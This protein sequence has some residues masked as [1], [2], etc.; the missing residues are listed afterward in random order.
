M[1]YA[2]IDTH[3]SSYEDV[4]KWVDEWIATQDTA[5]YHRGI[6]LLP[7]RW[8]KVIENGGNYFH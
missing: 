7:K 6:A 5:F 1:Q 2:L 8:E 3:F 4:Q